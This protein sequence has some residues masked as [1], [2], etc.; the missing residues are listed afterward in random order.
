[1]IKHS[2]V[3]CNSACHRFDWENVF[4]NHL[5]Q[6][7]LNTKHQPCPCCGGKDRFRLFADW[8]ETGGSICNQCGHGDGIGLLMK[9]CN[10]R[11]PEVLGMLSDGKSTTPAIK[12]INQPKQPGNQDAQNRKRNLQRCLQ[13]GKLLNLSER[14]AAT[15][16]LRN[17]GLDL[18]F[19]C[20]DKPEN[21]FHSP[22]ILYVQDKERSQSFNCLLAAVHDVD[23]NLVGGHRIYLSADGQKAPVISPKKS[24]PP[25]FPGAMNGAAVRLFPAK[26][27]LCITEGIETALAVKCMRPGFPVWA[28]LTAGGMKTLRL[29][30]EVCDVHIFSDHDKSGV[31]I[32]AAL[33]LKARLI[34]EGRQVTLHCPSKYLPLGVY[35]DWLDVLS[36]SEK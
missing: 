36:P 8:P 4:K 9:Y 18:L 30:A 25:I 5:P 3:N 33:S 21:L 11:F 7:T 6:L 15:Q 20:K 22:N 1:M 14:N 31:G 17:R 32:D 2:F 12:V 26:Y 28:T 19:R 16:Y 29:P 23:G 27:S 35:G 13:K 24:L 34:K 10:L